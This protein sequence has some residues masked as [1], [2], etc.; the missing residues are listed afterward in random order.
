VSDRPTPEEVRQV[1][2]QAD[3]LHPAEAVEAALDRT[4]GAIAERLAEANPLILGVMVGGIVPL[5]CLL[6]RLGFPLEVDYLHATRYRGGVRGGTLEW[7]ARPETPLTGRVVLVVDD[8]L[9]EGVTLSAILDECRA[10]GA[11]EVLSAVLVHKRHTRKPGIQRA[12]FSALEVPDRY[13]FGYGMDYRGY[14]R[15][16]RGVYAVRGL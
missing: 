12:D 3:L 4:A 2:A 10:A 13:V 15:N 9:D 7:R 1:L 16:A 11:R 14:L 8:I 6:P 5:G